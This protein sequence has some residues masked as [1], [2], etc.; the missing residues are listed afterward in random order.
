MSSKWSVPSGTELPLIGTVEQPLSNFV[1]KQSFPA[2]TQRFLPQFPGVLISYKSLPDCE[3]GFWIALI[4]KRI[5]HD[6]EQPPSNFVCKLELPLV[7]QR[8]LPQ[9][10]GVLIS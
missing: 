7:T 5:A 9:F 3:K 6:G 2:V 10:P 8:F 4:D 1:W